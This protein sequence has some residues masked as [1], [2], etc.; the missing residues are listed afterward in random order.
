MRISGIRSLAK[1]IIDT[2][3]AVPIMFRAYRRER[4]WTGKDWYKMPRGINGWVCF[5]CGSHFTNT[6]TAAVH[7][8]ERPSMTV[9]CKIDV[10][11][12]RRMR[13]ALH[14]A[15]MELAEKRRGDTI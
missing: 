14:E 5:H 12:Y 4:N 15:V 2:A 10:E 1:D 13:D 7:F 11:E 3:S 8:G 9:G 6:G